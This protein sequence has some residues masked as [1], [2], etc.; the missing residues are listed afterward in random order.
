MNDWA[1]L[2]WEGSPVVRG[3]HDDD[4]PRNKWWY[5]KQP[6]LKEVDRERKREKDRSR[7]RSAMDFI[8]EEMSRDG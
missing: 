3:W 5:S 2:G 8:W 7:R 4:K 1:G 6:A